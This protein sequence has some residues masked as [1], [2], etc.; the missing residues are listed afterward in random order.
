M[1]LDGRKGYSFGTPKYS[2]RK[3]P[4]LNQSLNFPNEWQMDWTLGEHLEVYSIDKG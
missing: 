2:E 4:L 3:A 1:G